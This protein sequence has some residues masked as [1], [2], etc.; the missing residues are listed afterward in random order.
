[1]EQCVVQSV[2][3]LTIA[4][5][6]GDH[7]FDD[8]DA[9][10]LINEVKASLPSELEH[11]HT[12]EILAMLADGSRCRSMLK[13]RCIASAAAQ[14]ENMI[15]ILW[16]ECRQPLVSLYRYGRGA[17]VGDQD[18][19][20]KWRPCAHAWLSRLLQVL[21]TTLVLAQSQS[22]KKFQLDA[23]EAEQPATDLSLDVAIV[24]T[25]WDKAQRHITAHTICVVMATALC[26]KNYQLIQRTLQLEREVSGTELEQLSSLCT[27]LQDILDNE[28]LDDPMNAYNTTPC[29]S[30][31][32]TAEGRLSRSMSDLSVSEYSE[33]ERLFAIVGVLV[34]A[35]LRKLLLRVLGEHACAPSLKTLQVL[36]CVDAWQS[37]F[38][39]VVQSGLSRESSRKSISHDQTASSPKADGVEAAYLHPDGALHSEEGVQL[40]LW[41]RQQ[42][43]IEQL[44]VYEKFSGWVQMKA[45]W[46]T[47]ARYL[48]L[49]HN[50][51]GVFTVGEESANYSDSSAWSPHLKYYTAVDGG[52]EDGLF[53]VDVNP[54]GHKKNFL[55]YSFFCTSAEDQQ[56]WIHKLQRHCLDATKA[57]E[58]A[59]TRARMEAL[60][61]K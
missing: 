51:L 31:V 9:L 3:Q 46:S 7:A 4:A 37:G 12:N 10:G 28:Q 14:P 5:K 30:P 47:G 29:S 33:E 39:R 50:M 8:C 11:D 1:M 6:N 57:A 20:Y 21:D 15:H 38:E 45:G 16:N 48:V 19:L 61:G 25:S 43:D 24:E 32:M 22:F 55:N 26:Y 49:M 59:K 17:V 40:W 34:C 18:T 23:A 41:L 35:M 53:K 2:A 58:V 27:L 36:G 44:V 52:C 54:Q 56:E 60:V 42:S 13:S